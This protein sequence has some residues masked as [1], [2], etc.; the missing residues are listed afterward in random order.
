MVKRI[1][2][3]HSQSQGWHIQSGVRGKGD[4]MG[5]AKA[6]VQLWKYRGSL[7]P[8]SSRAR[9]HHHHDV[10]QEGQKHP[11]KS[12][13]CKTSLFAFHARVTNRLLRRRRRR[14]T[15][16]FFFI[17]RV[18]LLLFLS[19]LHATETHVFVHVH[20]LA[21]AD[22]CAAPPAPVQEARQP[23]LVLQNLLLPA[24]LAT[25]RLISLIHIHLFRL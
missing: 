13:G 7:V 6:S 15:R 25:E 20:I 3:F 8:M 21:R 17:F 5:A 12:R 4:N 2:H 23:L 11:R 14:R 1:H 16:A 10:P 19:A 18:E 22:A 24:L 9:E